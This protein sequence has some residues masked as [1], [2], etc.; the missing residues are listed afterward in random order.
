[1]SKEDKPVR[2]PITRERLERQLTEAVKAAHADC[3]AFV[4]VVIERIAPASGE[5][6]NWVIKG[7]RYGTASREL[8]DT[9]LSD[10]VA[11]KQ[12]RFTLSD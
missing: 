11:E 5:D 4:G 6:T 3:E 1:M 7:I 2:E 12:L 8:C 10:S 9:A